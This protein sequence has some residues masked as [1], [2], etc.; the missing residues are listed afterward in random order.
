MVPVRRWVPDSVSWARLEEAG[1]VPL[2]HLL[3]P[4]AALNGDEDGGGYDAIKRRC[5][6]GSSDEG[7]ETAYS[8][9][10]AS[11]PGEDV[12]GREGKG[13]DSHRSGGGGG[14][15]GAMGGWEGRNGHGGGERIEGG[16]GEPLYLHD[17]SLPQNL[18]LDSSLLAGRFQVWRIAHRGESPLDFCWFPLHAKSCLTNFGSFE[19]W[20]KLTKTPDAII[21]IP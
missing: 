1:Q 16:G 19:M 5:D 6:G 9:V 8:K 13:C 17:W 2:A 18:G 12:D 20:F 7:I 3:R 21:G 10:V 11:V 14:I 4:P 15:V